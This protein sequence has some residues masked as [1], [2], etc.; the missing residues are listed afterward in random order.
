M[1]HHPAK[2]TDA[3]LPIFAE[4]LV[5]CARVLDPFAGTGKIFELQHALPDTKIVGVEIEK[6]WATMRA[7]TIQANA[8]ALPFANNHFDA[9]CTSPTYSNRMADHHNA[10]DASQR[11]T[12]RHNLNHDLHPENSDALQWGQQYRDF[13]RAAWLE[14][15]RVLQPDRRAVLNCKDHIR[16]GQLIPVTQWHVE[17]LMSLGFETQEW[18]HVI[19]PGNRRGANHHLRVE[20]ESV[21][22][23]HLNHPRR[24]CRM[25]L[26]GRQ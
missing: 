9:I 8:L 19:C 1:T 18:R 16:A 20:F 10:Q 7:G 15:R 5:G 13:H 11:N 6:P 25:N 3:L 12:Y 21:I 4:M 14:I 26:Q 23:F 17:T 24:T 2:Y 22:L